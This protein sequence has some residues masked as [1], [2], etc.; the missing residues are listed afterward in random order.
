MGLFDYI[1]G[2]L[3]PEIKETFDN[4]YRNY[5]KGLESFCKGYSI[6]YEGRVIST[7]INISNP[8]YDDMKRIY[9][10]SDNII[11]LHQS[12]IEKEKADAD[13]SELSSLQSKYPHAFVFFCN[14]CLG[15][16]I[17]NKNINMP[18]ERVSN[19]HK[20]IYKT[21]EDILKKF[22]PSNRVVIYYGQYK[23]IPCNNRE[24]AI[25][26]SKYSYQ[27]EPQNVNDLNITDIRKL[28]DKKNL[29]NTKEK[30]I[31]ADLQVEDIKI[32]FEDEVL[33]NN[34]RNKYY[35]LYLSSVSK[36]ESDTEFLVK[37]L[38]SLDSFITRHINSLFDELK[39]NYPLG[40][41]EFMLEKEFGESDLDIK[42][43]TIK[44]RDRIIY[45]DTICKEY[46]Q[47]KLKYPKGLPAFERH[48]SYDD[49]KNSASLTIEEI[50]KCENEIA[51]FETFAE[52]H[53]NFKKW[54]KEQSEFASICRHLCPQNFGCY[55]YDIE[56]SGV[57]ADGSNVAGQYKVW[58]TFYTSFYKPL[59][60]TIL[61]EDFAYLSERADENQKFLTGGWNY[62]NSVYDA[63]WNLI[64]AYREKVGDISIV[65][66][67][68]G[69]N[70]DDAFCFNH[71]KYD[72]LISKL[73]EA[74]IEYY[75]GE[76]DICQDISNLTKHIIIFEF[77]SSNTRLKQT[78]KFI[79]EKFK[80][81]Y[82]LI[83]YISLRKGYDFLEV[84]DI[85]NREIQKKKAQKEKEEAEK[86]RIQE[87]REREIKLRQE[88]ERRKSAE[89]LEIK[90][91]VSSW[92]KPRNSNIPCFS[93]Y[94]YYPTTCEWEADEEEW[95]VR[96]L[97]W[98][99]KA[100]PNRPQSIYEIS[101]RHERAKDI[102]IPLLNKVLDHFFDTN[103]SKLTLVCVPASKE[104]V[105]QR[106]FEDFSEELCETS[107]M[108]NG[109][110]HIHFKRDG[111]AT[112]LGGTSSSEVSLDTEFFKGKY[113]LLFDD[114]IT[115]GRSMEKLKN[116]LESLGAKVIGGLS[117]GRTKH[118]Y[119]GCN[120]IDE[121]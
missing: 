52:E 4:L 81:D 39:K 105:N 38:N 7:R 95:D 17:Y 67:S 37:N 28:L 41:K 58:Q 84:E 92:S 101:A 9:D 116:K 33:D 66:A 110:Y 49:G 60:G 59:P 15:G 42:E 35:K 99:F 77:V 102:V 106:R 10:N 8:S 64:T 80:S 46:E 79:R 91:C 120:P 94:Y 119:Q 96:N 78:V 12:I 82:P 83:S 118:E 48:Y 63:V 31:L 22:F 89:I 57:G 36:S 50:V 27:Y 56:F 85:I 111:E 109:Y 26:L 88:E 21:S 62:K 45:L 40:V 19:R 72:Y 108:S 98:D 86:K 90:Q 30:E 29:F 2:I 113:V 11:R 71:S 25:S 87:E 70:S 93:L 14:E 13:K 114:V 47:L 20:R 76:A 117:I 32:K 3:N 54:E 69:L 112:H 18:G 44:N 43:R 1:R 65:F 74:N 24:G 16:V 121:I 23:P 55:S 34:R 100:N 53:A 61:C 6:V 73:D 97:I 75:E 5:Y 103:V 107:N 115:S 51:K 104:A 68:N